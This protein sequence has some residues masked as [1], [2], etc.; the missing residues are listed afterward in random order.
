VTYGSI[1]DLDEDLNKEKP[2]PRKQFVALVLVV[3]FCVSLL[4]GYIGNA[5]ANLI[6]YQV[7][8]THPKDNK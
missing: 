4:G 2:M 8:I 6:I 5:I 1:K 7:N 3:V